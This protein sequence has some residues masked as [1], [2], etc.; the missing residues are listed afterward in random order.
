[1]AAKKSTRAAETRKMFGDVDNFTSEANHNFMTS[2]LFKESTDNQEYV[3]FTLKDKSTDKL[4]SLREEYLKDMDPTGYTTA[5]RVFGSFRIWRKFY[6]NKTL[7]FFLEELQEEVE[8]KLRVEAIMK[9]REMDNPT[10]A[11]WLSDKGWEAKRGRPTK[12]EVQKERKKEAS[13]L[14]E[15]N[16]DAE[17]VLQVVK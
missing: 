1:M 15:L 2:S 4:V 8:I 10:A 11:K 9:M 13:L 7:R 17:R 14:R 3:R 6:L 12:D 5:M 16:E